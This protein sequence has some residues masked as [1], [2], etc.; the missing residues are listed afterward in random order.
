MAERRRALMT[1]GER[2]ILFR[3]EQWQAKWIDLIEMTLWGR[4]EDHENIAALTARVEALTAEVKALREGRQGT[5]F[6]QVP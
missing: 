1:G 2:E 5:L 4:H 3:M 6:D